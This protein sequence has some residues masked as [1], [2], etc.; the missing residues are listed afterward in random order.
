MH[1]EGVPQEKEAEDVAIPRPNLR[2]LGLLNETTAPVP[3]GP[4]LTRA[5]P[6]LFGGDLP[7]PWLSVTQ[8]GRD[9]GARP[10]LVP[11]R[12]GDRGPGPVARPE[13]RLL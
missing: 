4:G 5:H 6:R 9:G 3:E 11:V 8:D 12:Q 7:Q 13:A 1:P 2:P 10:H